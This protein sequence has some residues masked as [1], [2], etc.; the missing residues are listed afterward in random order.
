[1]K[2]TISEIYPHLGQARRVRFQVEPDHHDVVYNEKLRGKL[3]LRDVDI[4]LLGGVRVDRIHPDLLG[5]AALLLVAPMSKRKIELNIPVSEG[6]KQCA[7]SSG[8]IQVHAPVDLSLARRAFP[9]RPRPGLAFSGGVD[10][11][12][13]LLLMSPETVPV[14]LHRRRPC[15]SGP[16]NYND[17]AALFSCGKA[18]EA[19]YDLQC[20]GTSLEFVRKP[21]GNPV[22]WSNSAPAIVNADALSLDSISFGMIAESAYWTGGPHFSDLKTRPR[23]AAWAPVFEYCGVPISL[24]TAALSEVLTYKICAT[25]GQHLAPQS[26]VRGTPSNP[27]MRCF[28][29]FRKGLVEAA[30]RRAE[31]DA[32]IL[33]NLLPRSEVA[34]KLLE[35]PIHHE[36]VIAWALNRCRNPDHEFLRRLAAKLR[37]VCDFGGSLAFLERY[38]SKGLEYTVSAQRAGVEQ[39]IRTFCDPMTPEDEVHLEHWMAEPLTSSQSYREGQESL[40]AVLE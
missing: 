16:S 25:S 7:A 23:F 19:G 34:G 27:C 5:L 32:E 13:A 33:A 15:A 2:V 18:L 30:L 14:F 4:D 17:S 10:S 26:C 35:V 37:V 12:A 20:I 29:C 22:D 39:K 1:M 11:C 31:P 21:V 36:I 3:N 28:K 8:L 38:Y 24:P 40:R 6:F 9:T